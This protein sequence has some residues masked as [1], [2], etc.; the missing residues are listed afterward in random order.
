VSR[1]REIVSAAAKQVK[2]PNTSDWLR[3][4]SRGTWEKTAA[5]LLGSTADKAA[6]LDMTA[7]EVDAAIAGR[8][9]YTALTVQVAYQKSNP[10]QKRARRS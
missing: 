10:R 9:A 7:E 3:V 1:A 2:D 8:L 4:D 6:S 5:E